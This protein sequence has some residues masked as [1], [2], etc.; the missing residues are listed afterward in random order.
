MHEDLPEPVAPDTSTW[1]I[2]ARLTITARPA[3]SRPRA[4]SRGWTARSAS[5]E[6]RMS[7]R[8]TS[9]RWRLGTSTPMADLPG[10]GARMRTSG[11]AMA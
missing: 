5:G 2:S 9:W 6:A 1:G 4:T 11:E 8:A 10:I 3:M 7:P